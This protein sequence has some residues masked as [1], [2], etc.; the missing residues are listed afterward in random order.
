MAVERG[1]L[2]LPQGGRCLFLHPPGRIDLGALTPE[3]C[4]AV[5]PFRPDF[6]A[7]MQRGI[8]ARPDMGD[9]GSVSVAVVTLPRARALVA[10]AVAAAT[11][12]VV[13]DGAKTNG[14]ETMAR[15]LRK[16]VDLDGVFSKAHGKLIWFDAGKARAADWSDWVDRPTHADGFR[17][18][19][20]VFSADG[21][22]PAS[23]LLAEHL[24][25][26][27]GG[28][29]IDLG[30]GWGYLSAQVLASG[31]PA[32][33]DLVDADHRALECAR[34]NVTDARAR[35]FWAD[36]LGWASEQPA[37]CAVMNPPFHTNREA[38]PELGR[39]FISAAARCLAPSGTLW[40]VANRHL[41]YEEALQSTF[42]RVDTFGSNKAFKMFRASR[43]TRRRG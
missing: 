5:Q 7:L 36:A 20:G 40:M 23:A 2:S 37:D 24:P 28:H 32:R 11:D 10:A 22:D 38:D 4:V 27:D 29:V 39:G 1:L 34:A 30:A 13:V 3:I 14:V 6:D 9:V 8:D 12:L 19:P 41:P 35:F 26:M 17:T 15:D 25:A 21:V 31:S 33:I 18:C 43:P 16:R 42:L